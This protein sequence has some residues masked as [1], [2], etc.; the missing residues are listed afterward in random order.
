MRILIDKI[1]FWIRNGFHTH[2][3]R[4]DVKMRTLAFYL[5]PEPQG[6][7]FTADDLSFPDNV[8]TLFGYMPL[9]LAVIYKEGWNFLIQQHGYEKLFEINNMSEW[10]D[11][12]TL[13]EFIESLAYEIEISP[14]NLE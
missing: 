1:F 8:E 3:S 13:D 12:E 10:I 9:L 6:T 11:C 14:Q 2:C 5:Y 4:K 7:S